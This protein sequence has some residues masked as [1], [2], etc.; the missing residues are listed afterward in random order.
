M[1]CMVDCAS[2]KPE[3]RLEIDRFGVNF[4]SVSSDAPPSELRDSLRMVFGD[5][6]AL[7]RLFELD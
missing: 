6:G 3:I 2:R 1:D 7:L 4:L 5:D